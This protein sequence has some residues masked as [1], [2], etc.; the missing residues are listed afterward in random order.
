[1]KSINLLLV[2]PVFMLVAAPA[3]I[4]FTTNIFDVSLTFFP[5]AEAKAELIKLVDPIPKE[6]SSFATASKVT[7]FISPAEILPIF[8]PETISPETVTPSTMR[9][10]K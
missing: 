9:L 8:N 10:P 1:M 3:T 5:P 2:I 6:E 4:P 7:T